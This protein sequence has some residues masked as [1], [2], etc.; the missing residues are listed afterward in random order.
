MLP[1]E[2]GRGEVEVYTAVHVFSNSNQAAARFNYDKVWLGIGGRAVVAGRAARSCRAGR[3]DCST[4]VVDYGHYG[5]HPPLHS[6]CTVARGHI[7]WLKLFLD[8]IC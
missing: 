6:V 3:I 7:V 2:S 4:A 1:I 5:E 8:L